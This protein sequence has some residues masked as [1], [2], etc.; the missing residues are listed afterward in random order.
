[1]TKNQHYGTYE[2]V[3][4]EKYPTELTYNNGFPNLEN[5]E[6]RPDSYKYEI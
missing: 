4:D 3:N 1:M 6:M 2:I 5:F